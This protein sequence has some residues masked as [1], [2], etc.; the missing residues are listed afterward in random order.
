MEALRAENR[1]MR[2]AIRLLARNIRERD[3]SLCVVGFDDVLRLFAFLPGMKKQ[4]E[5]IPNGLP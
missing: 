5:S 1:A 2:E 3:V 4:E